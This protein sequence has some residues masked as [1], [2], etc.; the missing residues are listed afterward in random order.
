M[1]MTSF[2]DA[3]LIVALVTTIYILWR[4]NSMIQILQQEITK[5]ERNRP[6][7]EGL[8]E[9]T[10]PD[11]RKPEKWVIGD[12]NNP[13]VS[14]VPVIYDAKKLEILSSAHD[15]IGLPQPA[16]DRLQA[17]LRSVPD[18][19]QSAENLSSYKVTFSAG[20]MLGLQTGTLELTQ[21]SGNRWLAVAQGVNTKKFVEIGHATGQL[22]SIAPVTVVW[23]IMAVITAQKFLAVIDKRLLGLEHGVLEIIN[24]LRTEQK[25]ELRAIYAYLQQIAPALEEGQCSPVDTFTYSSTIEQI[26]LRCSSVINASKL[27]LQP[28][29]DALTT[30]TQTKKSIK[31]PEYDKHLAALKEHRGDILSAVYI[32]L[33]ATQLKALL[34][35]NQRIVCNRLD[36][37]GLEVDLFT[38]T[39]DNAFDMLE[40]YAPELHLVK[41]MF[42]RSSNNRFIASLSAEIDAAYDDINKHLEQ[43]IDLI[44]EMADKIRA[45]TKDEG[46]SVSFEFEAD[47]ERRIVAARLL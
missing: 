9:K 45:F 11:E 33:R 26:E 31:K 27:R 42:G 8:V 32:R 38:K 14:L 1:Q 15:E 43:A 47:D 28:T 10:E 12:A 44:P 37:I 13:I 39:I 40:V 23:Q 3:A 34:P 25:G 18:I 36:D 4:Y 7:N 20:T 21:T 6:S 29:I 35:V 19:I 17:L 5:F 46:R 16:L 41:R 24:W 22:S 30:A 2:L